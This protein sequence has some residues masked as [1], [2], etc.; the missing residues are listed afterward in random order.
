M[1][2]SGQ[3]KDQN[4]E[5]RDLKIRD[6]IPIIRKRIILIIVITLLTTLASG[7]I[8]IYYLKPIYQAK[9]LLMVT[10]ATETLQEDPHQISYQDGQKSA[11]MPVLTMNTYLGQLKSEIVMQ[12][13]INVLDLPGETVASLSDKVNATIVKDSNLINLSVEHSDPQMATLIANTIS[14]K[15]L[16]LMK[17][18]MFS[19]VVVISPAITPTKPV[20]PNIKM[21]IL[22]AF[23]LGLMLSVMLSLQLEYL[24][25]TLKTGQDINDKLDMPVLGLIP[26]LSR[27]ESK[28]R[29]I[30]QENPKALVSEAYRVLRTNIGFTN[31]DNSIRSIL[32]TS[33]NAQ[34]GK[35]TVASNLAVVMAQAGHKVIL[36][37]CDLRKPMQHKI[38]RLDNTRGLTTCVSQ[39][40]NVEDVAHRVMGENLTVLTSGVLPPMPAELLNFERT[41]DFLKKLQNKYDYVLL[42][43]PPLIAVADA[44][45]LASQVN[46]VMLVVKAEETRIDLS[47]QA[48]EQL[49]KAN[50]RIIGAVLNKVNIKSDSYYS[51]KY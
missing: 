14:E 37:D 24:D 30:S 13:V 9:T 40:L 32:V 15:Y 11:A 35:S 2:Q 18:L 19:S 38:F 20:K 51:Y 33:V 27:N 41:R 28:S 31:L 39:N 42:D 49:I 5:Q 47:M 7:L 21:N 6:I 48:K 45:V 8:S 12:R 17:E 46:G 43:S 10:V 1:I 36:V 44:T 23:L 16:Q 29:L 34:D 4:V 26:T 50:A 25:N 22:I 3:R